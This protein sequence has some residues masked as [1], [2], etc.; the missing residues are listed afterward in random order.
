MGSKDVVTGTEAFLL[1]HFVFCCFLGDAELDSGLAR[2]LPVLAV[3][4]V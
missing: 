3:R 4:H 2:R 1:L